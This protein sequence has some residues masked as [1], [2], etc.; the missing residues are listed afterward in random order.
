MG[1][2]SVK[3]NKNIY[4]LSRERL[5]LSREAAGERL[6]CLSPDRIEKIESGRALPYPDEVLAME[7]GYGDV[8]LC[9]HYCT[10][11]CPIGRIYM[12]EARLKELP[13]VTVTLLAALNDL[14]GERDRLIRI[15]VD[16]RVNDF[17]RRDFDAVL[18]KLRAMDRAIQEMRLWI[19]HAAQTGKLDEAT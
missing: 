13:Q 11:E 3:E 10:R 1:R 5:G 4:Q 15:S 8:E 9:N 6:G 18:D 17:E 12:P 19:Q 7:Q 2:R 16:G 14:E